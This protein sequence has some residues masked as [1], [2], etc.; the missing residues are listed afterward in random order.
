M[1]ERVNENMSEW[2]SEWDTMYQYPASRCLDAQIPENSDES[3]IAESNRSAGNA[4]LS[5]SDRFPELFETVEDVSVVA[6]C[7]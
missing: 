5:S 6:S 3:Q 1:C 4:Y 2:E 7:I